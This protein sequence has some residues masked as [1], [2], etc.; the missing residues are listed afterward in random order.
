MEHQKNKLRR[1]FQK[2]LKE[3]SVTTQAATVE[4]IKKLDLIEME[5]EKTFKCGCKFLLDWFNSKI[6]N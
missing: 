1:K 6:T 3:L 4:A 5:T 2:K